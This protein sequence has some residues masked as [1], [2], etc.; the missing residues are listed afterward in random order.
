MAVTEVGE[1]P[2]RPRHCKRPH[3][4]DARGLE[5]GDDRI[6]AHVNPSREG[7]ADRMPNRLCAC[8]RPVRAFLLGRFHCS[9][10]VALS[11]VALPECVAAEDLP[12]LS[13]RR[14][15]VA[16]TVWVKDDSGQ[17][18]VLSQPARRIVSLIPA[19]TEVLFAIGAGDRI[20]GRTRFDHHPPEVLTVRSVGDGIRP[21]LELVLSREPDL[22][23]LFAGRDNLGVAAQLRRLGLVTLAVNHNSLV[24]LERNLRRL[25]R[26][27]GCQEGAQR[28][29]DDIRH[30]LEEVRQATASLPRRRVY[31]DLWS[32]PTITVGQGSY[33]DSLLTLAGG[34]N[35]FGDLRGSSPQ[36]SLEAIVAVDPDVILWA[37]DSA[38]AVLS[39]PGERPGW[40]VL[41]AVRLGR[42][43]AVNSGLVSRLGP[44]IAEATAVLA[45]AIH[46]E[47]TEKLPEPA[48][49]AGT[50]CNGER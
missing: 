15:A 5:S 39:P 8:A 24:D 20:V 9:L 40:R 43:R 13:A 50:A 10:G 44:R 28:L 7:C 33:L 2:T 1:K 46:P 31:Y 14:V 45:A 29:L 3:R 21:N 49:T 12:I 30:G 26:V 42:V 41:R 17:V 16:D 38:A 6:H 32:S 11:L 19:L 37:V 27:T 36:V 25:G 35:V 18:V 23:V 4:A 34:R 48:R 47:A 22:V